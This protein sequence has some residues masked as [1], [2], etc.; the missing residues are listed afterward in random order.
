MASGDLTNV[1]AVKRWLGI[2]SDNDDALL[3]ELISQVSAFV[4]NTIQRTVLTTTDRKS[5]V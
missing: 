1:S 2:S 5:V 4:E 3:T